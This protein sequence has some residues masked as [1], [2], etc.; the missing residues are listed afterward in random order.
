MKMLRWYITLPVMWLLF[1]MYIFF[2]EQHTFYSRF[3]FKIVGSDGFIKI[4][5]RGALNVY[6]DDPQRI[7]ILSMYKPTVWQSPLPP[8]DYML[9]PNIFKLPKERTSKIGR[10]MLDLVCWSY[11]LESRKRRRVFTRLFSASSAQEDMSNA[12]TL[13]EAWGSRYL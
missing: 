5:E 1:R 8:S 13:A 3:G 6:L 4:V 12:M 10:V 11:Y 2:K 9:A 7:E